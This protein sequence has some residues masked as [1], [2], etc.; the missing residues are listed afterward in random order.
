MFVGRNK[1][2]RIL[3]DRYQRNSFELCILYGKKGVG[4]T[5][6]LREFVKDK[7]GCFY[8]AEEKND[9]LNIRSFC[10]CVYQFFDVD[11][12]SPL[13]QKWNDIFS[14][15]SKQKMEE[16][17]VLI[18]DE[19]PNLAKENK[20]LMS[21]LQ[22]CIDHD[23]MD[24]NIM[25]ILSG[26]SI[27]F[28]EDEVLGYQSPLYGRRTT[29][30]KLEPF[31]YLESVEFYPAYSDEDKIR[32]YSIYGGFPRSLSMID[33]KRSVRDNVCQT[34][35]S[36]KSYLYDDPVT[37]LKS[38]VRYPNIYHSILDA[39]G[40][41]LATVSEIAKKIHEEPVK[42]SKCIHTLENLE[43]VEM[44]IPR[45]EKEY[46]RNRRYQIS[47]SYVHFWY[48]MISAH[49]GTLVQNGDELFYDTFILPN[50]DDY[51]ALEFVKICTQYMIRMSKAGKLP[52]LCMAIRGYW[53]KNCEDIDFLLVGQNSEMYCKCKWN[54]T[55]LDVE[56]IDHLKA[57]AKQFSVEDRYYALFSKSGF[58]EG[59]KELAKKNDHVTL[60]EVK[61]LF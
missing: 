3:H 17:F 26:S 54:N 18:I 9:S 33:S 40:K 58:T 22:H 14:F 49:R 52:F 55:P 42:C 41:G 4:K 1:E 45:G 19:F 8:L 56:D 57:V 36:S 48:Y 21:K 32:M 38:E 13:L 27:P 20:S 35:L 39:M 24:K 15:I 16:R 31:D 5:S 61:D 60:V 23:W 37:L 44:I 34:I 12:A 53:K 46:S 25:L 2:L 7:K 11:S 43:M 30:L 47:D 29:K 10:K 51:L 59:V 28:M 6:L 50:L